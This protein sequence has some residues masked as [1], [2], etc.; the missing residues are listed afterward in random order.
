MINISNLIV[1]FDKTVINNFNIS[2]PSKGVFCIY[3]PS[4][5]GKTTLLNAIAGLV[6]FSGNIEIDGKISYLFQE[7]RLLNWLTAK[8]NIMIVEPENEKVIK[9]SDLFGVTEFI[10]EMPQN[11]SGGMKRRVAL[12]RTLAYNADIYLLDEPFK[13]LDE[14]NVEKVYN[15]IKEISED[16]LVLVVTHNEQDAVN[17]NAEKILL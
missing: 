4:G 13:G 16:K 14:C 11:L 17:L 8:E 9:Y 6:K 15:A 10:D 5:T 12:V 1:K 7:D 3:A 2:F